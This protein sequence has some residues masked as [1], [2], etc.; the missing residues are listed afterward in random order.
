MLWLFV[1]PTGVYL[2]DFFCS[3]IQFYL[4]LKFDK[5]G[6][7]WCILGVPKLVNI[8]LKINIFFIINQKPKFC[9]IFFSKINPDAH[10]GTLWGGGGVIALRSQRNA[11]NGGFM[12]FFYKY[13]IPDATIYPVKMW[14]QIHARDAEFI[15]LNRFNTA[16]SECSQIRYH[17]PKNQQF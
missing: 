17:Q 9:A 13:Y 8:N 14:I 12:F 10:F 7:V 5:N 6:G 4:L 11:K 16:H 3:G 15:L 1:G 2:L